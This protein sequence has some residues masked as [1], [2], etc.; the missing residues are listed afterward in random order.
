[1]NRAKDRN[2]WRLFCSGLSFEAFCHGLGFKIIFGNLCTW[3][4]RGFHNVQK[5]AQIYDVMR[6]NKRSLVFYDVWGTGE[7]DFV[8]KLQR[9]PTH[10]SNETLC[11]FVSQRIL[12]HMSDRNSVSGIDVIMSVS[13]V[14]TL[15]M[16]SCVVQFLR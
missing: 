5:D 2:L 11:S 12:A 10:A 8:R 4:D 14:S 13:I 3:N 6:S 9:R 16:R 15:A 1:M 7:V